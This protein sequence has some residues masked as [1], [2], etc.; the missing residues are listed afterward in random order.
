MN[1]LII[2][3][4]VKQVPEIKETNSGLKYANVVVEVTRNFRN[5]NGDYETDLIT[6]TMWRG[7]AESSMMYCVKD[8]IVGIKGRLQ[9]QAYTNE[10]G[11]TYYN[12]EVVVEKIS[13]VANP[14]K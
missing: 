14:N 12:Y 7:V 10:Q 3:G 8:A 5:S 4:K 1:H 2:V 9:S 13:F 6:C 11:N